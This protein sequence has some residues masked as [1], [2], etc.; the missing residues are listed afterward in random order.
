MKKLFVLFLICFSITAELTANPGDTTW[1]T[2]FNQKQITAYG[3]IDT[4]AVLPTGKRYRKIRLHYILGRYACPAGSQYCGSWDYTT[5]VYVK[6]A[7]ADTVEIARVITPYAT[8]WLTRGISN[9]Y[10]VDVTDYAPVL[11]GNVGMRYNYEGYSWGF[12]ITLKFELIEGVPPMDAVAVKNIYDGYYT[13]GSNTDLIENHLVAKTEQ[14]NSPATMAYVKNTISGHGSDDSGCSE[15]CSKYYQLKINNSMID[16]EQLWRK[17]CGINDIS[18]QTGTW[19]YER[20]NWCPGAIVDPIYHNVTPNTSA[21]SAFSVDIDM[22]PYSAPNQSNTSAGYN[23]VSQLISYSA[24]NNATDVSIE[25]IMAPTNDPNHARSNSICSHPKIKIKN[26]GSNAVTSVTFKYNLVGGTP[27]TYTW[28]GNLAFLEDTIV[29]LGS[30]VNVFNSNVSNSF[31]VKIDAVNG[32][33]GDGNLDNNYYRSNFTDVRSYPG[34]FVIYVKTNAAT[35]ASS[36]NSETTWRLLDN[37]GNVVFQRNSAAINT[38]YKDTVNLPSGCYTFIMDDES[39]DGL[40]FWAN[41]A[42]G[43]G[44][45]RFSSATSP[46]IWKNFS[47]DFGCRVTEN[48]TVGYLLSTQEMTAPENSVSLFPNPAADEVN[49]LFD[50]KAYQTV[51]YTIYDVSGKLVNNGQIDQVSSVAYPVNTGALRSGIYYI[52]LQF[53]DGSVSHQKFAISR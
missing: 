44:I 26:T 43:N 23:V 7:G 48:F 47:G 17:T 25:D 31:E 33:N 28:S 37:M 2:V 34:K 49:L 30:S 12:T 19:I 11:Q 9:D 52:T 22:E 40:S 18:P 4:S 36:S 6:P 5:Q 24:I 1:V 13:Y 51:H 27:Q 8:D 20:G 29:D 35:S 3:A 39:C 32:S 10:V 50:V 41:T 45:L 42:P 14:Y 38:T 53:A 15:F 46:A 21:N 16:Q